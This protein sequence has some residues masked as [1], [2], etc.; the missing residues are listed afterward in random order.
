MSGLGEIVANWRQT[1][2]KNLS[3]GLA[4]GATYWARAEISDSVKSSPLPFLDGL[5]VVLEEDA[6]VE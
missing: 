6:G 4:I 2:L 3:C 1:V 5:D